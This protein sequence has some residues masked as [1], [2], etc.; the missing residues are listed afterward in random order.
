MFVSQNM[1][2]D[3]IK[4]EDTMF[5]E[6]FE[7][8]LKVSNTNTESRDVKSTLTATVVYYTGVPV[9]KIKSSVYNITAPANSGIYSHRNYYIYILHKS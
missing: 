2:F 8:T 9:K 4:R 1:T 7:V 3:L 6:P 5:G